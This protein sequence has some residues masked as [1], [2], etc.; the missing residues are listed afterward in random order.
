MDYITTFFILG[1]ALLIIDLIFLGV[2]V[3]VFIGLGAVITSGIASLNLFPENDSLLPY[4]IATWAISS[5]I[6]TGALWK[7]LKNFQN[8]TSTSDTSSDLI[9]KKLKVTS[10]ITLNVD[11]KVRFSGIDWNAKA[12]SD[13]V[14]S[15]DTLENNSDIIVT[16]VIGN[17]LFVK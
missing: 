13:F 6:I 17:V 8:K 10:V 11:G 14:S 9:G 4:L 16:K 12:D 7:P 2:N 15:G 1:M 3:L 5:I